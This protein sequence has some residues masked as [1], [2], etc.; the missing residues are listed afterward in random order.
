MYSHLDIKISMVILLTSDLVE[1][2]SSAS[3]SKLAEFMFEIMRLI[4]KKKKTACFGYIF[5]HKNK[6]IT[7]K[8]PPQ[9]LA[10]E[11]NFCRQVRENLLQYEG[12]SSTVAI[13]KELVRDAQRSKVEINR[14]RICENHPTISEY[15]K[16][17]PSPWPTPTS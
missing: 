7:N 13:G 2:Q 15:K 5:T 10:K 9:Y 8:E 1:F 17:A 14:C 11:N 12:M 16:N 4:K 6:E 3:S